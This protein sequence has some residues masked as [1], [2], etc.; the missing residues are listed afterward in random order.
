MPLKD[1]FSKAEGAAEDLVQQILVAEGYDPDLRK[2][3]ALLAQKYG[4]QFYQL[5]TKIV[6]SKLV[7]HL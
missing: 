7:L 2:D 4:P 5:I 6:L 1:I 3:A